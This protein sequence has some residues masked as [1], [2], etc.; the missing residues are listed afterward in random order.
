MKNSTLV[1]RS[2][3]I[4][5]ILAGT[6]HLVSYASPKHGIIQDS[7]VSADAY[8]NP[9]PSQEKTSNEVPETDYLEGNWKVNYS[10][11]AFKGAVVYS[12]KKEGE[13]FHAYTYQYQDEQGNSEE[14]D[15]AKT[16]T[17]KSFDGTT[18]KGMYT[19]KYEQE[20]YEIDCVIKRVDDNTFTLSYDYYG[21]S[22]VETWKRQ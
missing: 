19:M 13:A 12:I 18:G 4:L 1:F 6:A 20:E 2:L 21:Y 9:K 5:I 16:L 8:S 3:A 10:T 17:I 22:D 7:E 11:E 15:G 14:A